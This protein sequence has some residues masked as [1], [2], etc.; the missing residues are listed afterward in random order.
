[1]KY[2]LYCRL[3]IVTYYESQELTM[4]LSIRFGQVT[5]CPY[6]N[7]WCKNTPYLQQMVLV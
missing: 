6:D 5:T 4:S 3:S 1:M 2:L 7:G